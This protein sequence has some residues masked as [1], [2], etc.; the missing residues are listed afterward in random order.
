MVQVYFYKK[1]KLVK[2]NCKADRE[3]PKLSDTTTDGR[4]LYL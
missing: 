1:K 2:Q 3:Q 4:A